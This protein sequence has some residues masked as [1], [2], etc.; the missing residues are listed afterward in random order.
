MFFSLLF[1]RNRKL[2]TII[3]YICGFYFLKTKKS[4][5]DLQKPKTK[6][7]MIIKQDLNSYQN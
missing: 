2:K 3:K 7:K 4:K 5:V 1:L 6:N